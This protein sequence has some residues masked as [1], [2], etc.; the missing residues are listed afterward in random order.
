MSEGIQS[1]RETNLETNPLASD[2]INQIEQDIKAWADKPIAFSFN[3]IN[4]HLFSME[5]LSRSYAKRFVDLAECIR[6]L[7]GTDRIVPATVLARVLIETIAVACLYHHDLARLL[8]AGDRA[9][10]EDRFHRFYSGIKDHDVKP[11]HVMDALRHLEQIDG[12]Y[13]EYLDK[14]Y[15]L[16]TRFAETLQV[17]ERPRELLSA[18]KNYD[19]LSEVSHPNGLGTQFLYPDPSNFSDEVMHVRQRFRHASIAAIWQGHHLL[20]SLNEHAGF[21]ERFK[22]KFL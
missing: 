11:V 2:R 18:M 4:T 1:T 10:L 14:K 17:R 9:K 20:K 7:V 8:K 3:P 6:S 19:L 5:E 12:E 13:V 15:G 22:A 21:A 16:L